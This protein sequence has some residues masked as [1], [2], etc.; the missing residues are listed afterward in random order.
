MLATPQRDLKAN[1]AKDVIER[2]IMS[3]YEE[4][5]IGSTDTLGPDLESSKIAWSDQKIRFVT[6]R[7]KNKKVLDLGCVQHNPG[8]ADTELWLH[9][10][11][12]AVSDETLGLDLYEP[13]VK[14][15][16]KKGYNVVHGNAENFDFERVFETI[17]A[18]DLVEHLSNF[19]NFLESCVKHMDRNSKLLICTPNPWHWHRVIRAFYRDIPVNGEHTCWMCPIT[20]KQLAKRYGLNVT[21]LEYGSSRLRDKFLLLPKRLRHQSWNAELM[22]SF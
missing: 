22:L 14:I 15:L 7:C 16:T 4:H 18:G 5:L 9:K 19:G 8:F 17:V 21:Y 1:Q 2:I 6:D 10:A 13:G 12:C 3:S 11:I 20:L